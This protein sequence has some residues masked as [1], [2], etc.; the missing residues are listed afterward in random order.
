MITININGSLFQDSRSTDLWDGGKSLRIK[1]KWSKKK[2][3][4][5]LL[6]IIFVFLDVG[7]DVA[8]YV[9]LLHMSEQLSDIPNDTVK[10]RD[11]HSRKPRS[12]SL[13]SSFPVHNFNQNV[14][15]YNKVFGFVC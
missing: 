8:S 5:L 2:N 3:S 10:R 4:L 7:Q 9:R 1:H 15:W 6:I 13:E 11:G 14:P 12:L